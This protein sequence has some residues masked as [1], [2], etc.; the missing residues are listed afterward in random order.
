MP[1][2]Q[3]EKLDEKGEKMKE[4][5]EINER[6]FPTPYTNVST[7]YAY[8]WND[9]LNSVMQHKKIKEETLS[10]S[11]GLYGWIC[12]KCGAVMSP[13]QSCC[14]KCSGNWEITF[15]TG[16]PYNNGGFSNVN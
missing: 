13:F 3:K 14:V 4:Y 9:C 8:G 12:P 2:M 10:T 16:T 15:N 11:S 7:E 1:T 5:I 6:T